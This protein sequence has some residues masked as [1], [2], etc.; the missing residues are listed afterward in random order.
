MSFAMAET[1]KLSVEQRRKSC[2][3][4]TPRNPENRATS[5]GCGWPPF[6]HGH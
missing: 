6:A 4:P 1:P 3:E 5:I 2:A